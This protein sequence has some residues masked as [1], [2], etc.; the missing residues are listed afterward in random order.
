MTND[1]YWRAA[2][3]TRLLLVGKRQEARGEIVEGERESKLMQCIT[4]GSLLYFYLYLCI[5][6]SCK[7]KM[8]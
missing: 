3:V 6:H 2:S 4:F 5:L 1:V 7:R 8:Y